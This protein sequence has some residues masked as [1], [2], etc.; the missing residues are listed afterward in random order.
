MYYVY[1][2]THQY[3]TVLYVGVTNNLVRRVYEHKQELVKG[4][5]K[6]YKLHKLVYYGLCEDV[7]RAI[8]REKELK[9]WH[10]DW[11]NK[12]ICGKN[13]TWKDLSREFGL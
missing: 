8:E 10:R 7:I 5:I 6:R 2:L 4:F 1:I 3:N 13:P 9:N 11:K 12:L